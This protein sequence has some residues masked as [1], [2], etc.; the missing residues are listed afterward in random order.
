MAK[1]YYWLKLQKDFFKRHDIRIVESMPNGKD[2]ILFYLKLLVESISHFGSLKFSDTIPYTA[3]MLSVVTNTNIDVVRTAIK[4]FTELGMIEILDD[5]TIFMKELDKLMGAETEWAEKKRLYR[6]EQR[7]KLGQ[8]EDNVL[9]LSDKSTDIDIE[10]DKEIESTC[11]SKKTQSRSKKFVIPTLEEIQNYCNEINSTIDPES[12][13]DYYATRDWMAGKVKMKD[14][15]ASVR[16]WT[17][18]ER[19]SPKRDTRNDV[20]KDYSDFGKWEE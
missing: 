5:Q 8:R 10:I 13:I 11:V 3:D 12:F 6:D 19:N 14:W 7:T 17:R 2:Y 18:R 20:D 9:R 4:I 16:I 1:R 15:K